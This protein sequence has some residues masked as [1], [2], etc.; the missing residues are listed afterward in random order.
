MSFTV[1]LFPCAGG[2]SEGFRRAGIEFDLSFDLD[3]NA[4]DSHE[5]N[6][7]Q[8]PIQVNVKDLSRLLWDFDP[9]R[10]IDFLVADPPCTPWSRAGKREGTADERDCLEATCDLIRDLSPRIW[11]IANVPGLDDSTNWPTVQKVIG[12]LT[13]YCIDFQRFD[14]ANYGV[15]QHRVRP[16]WFGHSH[17]TGHIQWPAPTHCDPKLGPALPELEQLKPWVTC[18]DALEHL[19]ESEIGRPIKLRRRPQ[20]GFPPSTPDAPAHTILAKP[21]KLDSNTMTWNPKHPPSD[22][23]RPAQA[24]NRL[25]W[26]WD[27]PATTVMA[28]KRIPPPGHHSN[29][30]YMSN[31]VALSEKAAAILQGFPEGWVFAGKTKKAR[32][33]QIGQ[34]VPPALAHAVATSIAAWFERCEIVGAA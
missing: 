19:P 26:P 14:A 2:M 33:A 10:P 3:E 1:E 25:V 27:R 7:G 29:N 28:D 6:L 9:K 5:A 15:P 8:R 32:W 13:D 34:A 20:G 17:D 12:S 24:N 18:R 22:P 30:S 31:G 16:F 23:D 21:S 11:M 4:C